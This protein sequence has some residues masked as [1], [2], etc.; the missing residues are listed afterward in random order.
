M[1]EVAGPRS[2]DP[3]EP[4]LGDRLVGR[5]A[6]RRSQVVL[7]IDPDPARLWPPALALAGFT[8]GV[9]R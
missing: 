3:V 1:A 9:N 2:V 6:A 5:V 7:G 8:G 4:A